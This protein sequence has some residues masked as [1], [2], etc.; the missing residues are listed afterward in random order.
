LWWKLAH[1]VEQFL[2]R[3]FTILGNRTVDHPDAHLKNGLGNI[4]TNYFDHVHVVL[5]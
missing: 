4:D 1:R 5:S 2:A 3:Y